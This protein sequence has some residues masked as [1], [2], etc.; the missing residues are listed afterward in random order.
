MWIVVGALQK[1]SNRCCPVGMLY[2]LSFVL[3]GKS[4]ATLALVVL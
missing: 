1:K 3:L 4:D 2:F